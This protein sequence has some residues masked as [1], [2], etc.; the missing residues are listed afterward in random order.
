MLMGV[1]VAVGVD[2][3]YDGESKRL[4]ELSLMRVGLLGCGE[5]NIVEPVHCRGRAHP[6]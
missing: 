2:S 6:L 3:G 1:D 4:Q 5:E